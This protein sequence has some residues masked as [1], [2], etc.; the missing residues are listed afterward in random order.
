MLSNYLRSYSTGGNNVADWL[1]NGRC[2]TNH[3]VAGRWLL[4]LIQYV[5]TG[6]HGLLSEVAVKALHRNTTE[7]IMVASGCSY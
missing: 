3:N 5:T 2:F 4:R 1:N 7:I 6:R